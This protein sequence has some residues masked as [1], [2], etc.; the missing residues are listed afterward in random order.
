MGCNAIIGLRINVE[1]IPARGD[2]LIT[3]NIYGTVIRRL[4][5]SSASLPDNKEHQ[6]NRPLPETLPVTAFGRPDHPHCATPKVKPPKGSEQN[7]Y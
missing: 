3:V 7:R 1:A 4:K 2:A 6:P 5:S